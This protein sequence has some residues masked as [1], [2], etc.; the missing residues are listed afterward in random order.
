MWRLENRGGIS[1]ENQRVVS[2]EKGS[3]H[4]QLCFLKVGQDFVFKMISGQDFHFFV[5]YSSRT[6]P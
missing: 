5:K 2:T 6:Q 1:F 3:D 4:Y